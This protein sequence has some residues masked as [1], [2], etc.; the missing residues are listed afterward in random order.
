MGIALWFCPVTGSQVYDSIDLLIHSLQTLIP[1][2]PLFEPHITITSGLN[3]TSQ[4]DVNKILTY[5]VAAMDS[6]K[7]R[8]NAGSPRSNGLRSSGSASGSTSGFEL[9][10]FK[11]LTIGKQFFKKVYMECDDNKYLMS[12]AKIMREM[13]VENGDEIDVQQWLD[14]QFKPHMSLLYSNVSPVSR[15]HQRLIKQRVEDAFDVP[16]IETTR[17][18]PSDIQAQWDLL[19]IPLI[20]W[21]SPGTFKIVRC[22]GPV[23]QW[24]ILGKA[25][26]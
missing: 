15:V 21:G 18:L 12:I 10:K 16:M 2:S 8:V 4:D 14:E 17:T 6:V 26:V 22:E 20:S 1:N 23:E 19:Q 25:D 13:F 5:C 7:P 11:N 9:V 3:I 24:E